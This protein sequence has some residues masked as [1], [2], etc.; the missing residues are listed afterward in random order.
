[1]E[2]K[3]TAMQN[4]IQREYNCCQAIV[5]TYCK[6]FNIK[7]KDVFKM[8]EGFGSG[9]GGLKDTCGAVVGMFLVLGM[10]NSAGNL[11]NPFKT[12][13][14]TY[15]KIKEV[16]KLFKR[17]CGS[18]YCWEIKNNSQMTCEKCVETAAEILDDYLNKK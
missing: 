13:Q 12:K 14:D 2:N 16:A 4:F 9:M 18:I 17:Q 3:E 7:E 8:T 11:H 6:I 5:C 10:V 15:K 1:M